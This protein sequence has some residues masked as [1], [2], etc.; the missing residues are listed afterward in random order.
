MNLKKNLSFIFRVDNDKAVDQGPTVRDQNVAMQM[1]G[2]GKKNSINEQ[3][4]FF[5]IFN[6]ILYDYIF[7]FIIK[8]K[9]NHFCLL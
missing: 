1:L 2:I 9:K 7:S 8:L 4:P 6:Q 5:I 3:I